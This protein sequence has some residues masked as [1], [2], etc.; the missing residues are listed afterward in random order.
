[1]FIFVGKKMKI[2]IPE[3]KILHIIYDEKT[4]DIFYDTGEICSDDGVTTYSKIEVFNVKFDSEELA[5]QNFRDF[6][7]ACESGKNAFYFG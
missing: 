2:A 1:M 6:Y 5:L 4:I 3:S 7:E